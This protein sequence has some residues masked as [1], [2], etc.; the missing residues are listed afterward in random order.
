MVKSAIK[1]VAKLSFLKSC[2]TV[3][4]STANVLIYLPLIIASKPIPLIKPI[5]SPCLCP[6]MSSFNLKPINIDNSLIENHH[7]KNSFE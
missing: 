2:Y 5:N 4:K 7:Y 3:R 1:S 6:L